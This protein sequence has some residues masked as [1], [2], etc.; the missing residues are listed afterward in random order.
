[1]GHAAQPKS[2]DPGRPSRHWHDVMDAIGD[3]S[4]RSTNRQ[5]CST[6]RPQITSRLV[7][8]IRTR[9]WTRGYAGAELKGQASL[10]GLSCSVWPLARR[11]ED[12]TTRGLTCS[13]L[14]AE[15]PCMACV[16]LRPCHLRL[17]LHPPE[18]NQMLQ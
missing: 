13:K 14:F 7:E 9:L 3:H 6:S 2:G 4:A 11:H 16:R 10:A 12:R 8:R 17:S 15:A 18:P 5:A 1:M